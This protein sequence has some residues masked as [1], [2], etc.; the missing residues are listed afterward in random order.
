MQRVDDGCHVVVVP[1]RH[2]SGLEKT[3]CDALMVAL[4][5]FEVTA[6]ALSVSIVETIDQDRGRTDKRQRVIR[7]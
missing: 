6:D 3:I 2:P 4:E 1:R 5:P 7:V